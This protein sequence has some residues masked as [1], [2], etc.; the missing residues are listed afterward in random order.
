[1]INERVYHEAGQAQ[2]VPLLSLF[3]ACN[4]T[5]EDDSLDAL[6]DR[7]LLRVVVPPLADDD[8]IRQL[9]DLQPSPPT[10]TI[11][12][13]ELRAA[14]SRSAACPLTDD[15]R[16]ALITIKHGLEEEGIAAVDRRWKSCAEL[17]RAKAWLEGESQTSSDHCEVLV[18][19]LW[20]EPSQIRVVERVGR[21]RS[22]TR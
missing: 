2:P 15:T 8:S 11:T 7:F 18:H 5:P 1:M 13:D 19:A 16:E 17:V 14:Q 6:Y 21:R 22:P 10:A 9:F 4:E 12:L 3:G 20:S